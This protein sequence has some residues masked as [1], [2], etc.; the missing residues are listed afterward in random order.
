VSKKDRLLT[1]I[2]IKTEAMLDKAISSALL[3]ARKVRKITAVLI[4]IKINTPG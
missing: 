4:S 3:A 1:P 2:P